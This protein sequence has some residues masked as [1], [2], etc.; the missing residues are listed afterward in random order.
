[1][2]AS[3]HKRWECCNKGITGQPFTRDPIF[4]MQLLLLALQ[5]KI[6][7]YLL[8]RNFAK[9]GNPTQ[10]LYFKVHLN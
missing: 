9:M 2:K 4:D 1:M 6:S 10:H 5:N 3:F 8:E 7:E